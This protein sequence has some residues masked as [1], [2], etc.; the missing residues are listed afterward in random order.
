MWINDYEKLNNA[1]KDTF[2]RLVN[3]ILA[4]TFV[5]RDYYDK[6]EKRMRVHNNYRFIER[7]FELFVEYLSF[8]G[9][10]LHKDNNYGVMYLNSEYE[11][12]KIGFNK[13][14]TLV[15]LTMRLIFEESREEIS[16]RNEVVIGV[17]SLVQKMLTLDIIQKKPSI[18][19]LADALR[20]LSKFKIIE[21]IEGKW[22][23]PDTDIIILPSIIFILSNEKIRKLSDLLLEGQEE[24]E[25]QEE[26]DDYEAS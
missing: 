17:N 8:G 20:T 15:L 2:K 4:K 3:L 24:I 6:D 16:I 1:E 10:K 13:F 23:N 21:R 7:N 9:W 26:E 14:T 5:I 25:G 22:E 19:E 12:N 11:Y 18:K